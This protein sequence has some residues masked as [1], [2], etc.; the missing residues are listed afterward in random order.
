MIPIFPEKLYGM[1]GKIKYV[2]SSI[3]GTTEMYRSY[4]PSSLQCKIASN[5]K[6]ASQNRVVPSV[7]LRS[8]PTALL[9]GRHYAGTS[10]LQTLFF[11]VSPNRESS[12]FQL[13]LFSLPFFNHLRRPQQRLYPKPHLPSVLFSLSKSIFDKSQSWLKA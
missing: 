11:L 12:Q 9:L 3:P 6:N 7:W 13:S 10:R 8:H 1:L 5:I 4:D 2:L